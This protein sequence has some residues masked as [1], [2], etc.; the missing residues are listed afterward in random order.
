MIWVYNLHLK[1]DIMLSDIYQINDDRTLMVIENNLL[2]PKMLRHESET[3]T[4]ALFKFKQIIMD[5]S[6][7]TLKRSFLY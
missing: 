4:S 1:T 2:I 5:F 7:D 6:T 3:I